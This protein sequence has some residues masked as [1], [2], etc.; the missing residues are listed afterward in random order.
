MNNE[1][2]FWDQQSS[3]LN[4]SGEPEF[5]RLKAAEH[6]EL[7]SSQD[8]LAGCIDLGCGAGEF[9]YFLA[10]HVKVEVGL[11]YSES[12]LESAKK[13]LESYQD[14]ELVAADIFDY[15][16][17]SKNY[18]WMS[19]GGINQY[20]DEDN[21]IDVLRIFAENNNAGSL[22]YFDCIDPIRYG[23]MSLGISYRAEHVGGAMPA[24]LRRRV[25][26]GVRRLQWAA[27]FAS[28]SISAPFQYLGR[29]AMGYGALPHFWLKASEGLGLKAEIVSSRYYEYRYHVIFRKA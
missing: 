28:G 18:V 24:T 11:D 23:L 13:N 22:Y 10:K 5:Y 9:L 20:L 27:K 4:R 21:S 7:F 3:S 16:P 1:K 12:M 14:I 26:Y 19:T 8:K 2:K 6:G 15:L 25:A 17:T 29:P